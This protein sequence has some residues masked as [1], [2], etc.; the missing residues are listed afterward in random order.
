M[1]HLEKTLT[2]RLVLAATATGIGQKNWASR[3]LSNRMNVVCRPQGVNMQYHVC[4]RS[5]NG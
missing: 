3:F 4:R 2:Q 5:T 1:M